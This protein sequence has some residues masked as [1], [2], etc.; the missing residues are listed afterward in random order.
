MKRGTYKL[1]VRGGVEN[2]RQ[3]MM[4]VSEG[5]AHQSTCHKLDPNETTTESLVSSS[6]S[7]QPLHAIGSPLLGNAD[8]GTT[9]GVESSVGAGEA[10]TELFLERLRSLS[11]V[12]VP[13]LGLCSGGRVGAREGEGEVI[14]EFGKV[15]A[16]RWG[17]SDAG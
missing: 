1:K 11:V 12:I 14:Q 16:E 9:E 5:S 7:L 2:S 15:G 4:T 13:E 17:Y 10:T 3:Y 6:P 8:A